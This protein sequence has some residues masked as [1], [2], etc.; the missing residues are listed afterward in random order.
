MAGSIVIRKPVESE[1]ETLAGLVAR[2]KSL[3]EEL[4]PN[5]KTVNDLLDAARDYIKESLKLENVIL[6]VAEDADAG[7]I[8]G[9]VRVE[10]KNRR[11]YEP[12]IKGVITDLYVH[13]S[14]RRKKVGALLV[15]KAV[16]ELQ[17]RGINMI[18]AI[19]PINNIIAKK[20]YENLGFTDLDL[21]VYKII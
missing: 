10:I 5:Y 6:L 7:K 4:D 18:T 8:V 14:Y 16:E 11:F 17:G 9:M 21:E 15:D 3:N 12:R 13:P 2:L 1:V 20:F 19:Y